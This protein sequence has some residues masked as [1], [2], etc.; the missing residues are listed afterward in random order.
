MK[1]IHL[2][3]YV[4]ILADTDT[5]SMKDNRGWEFAHRNSLQT[6]VMWLYFLRIIVLLPEGLQKS[7]RTDSI[8]LT[9]HFCLCIYWTISKRMYEH[10]L[11]NK[12]ELNRLPTGISCSDS[13][14][15]YSKSSLYFSLSFTHT[16]MNSLALCHG[17]KSQEIQ[18]TVRQRKNPQEVRILYKWHLQFSKIFLFKINSFAP[19]S[20]RVL[21]LA[22]SLDWVLCY[23]TSFTV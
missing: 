21:N 13:L 20:S 3:T 10:L 15:K 17:L 12:C 22:F 7:S 19:F 11:S 16:W 6:D 9:F 23:E 5:L 4:S 18:N 14:L 1:S 8:L 2:P